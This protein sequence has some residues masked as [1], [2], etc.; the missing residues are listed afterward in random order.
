MFQ[1]RFDGSVDFYRNWAEY[2]DGFG[3]LKG[4]FWLGNDRVSKMT[5]QGDWELRVDMGDWSTPMVKAYAKYNKFRLG[6]STESYTLQLDKNSF[7]G[8]AGEDY[9][10]IF[11]IP[12]IISNAVIFINNSIIKYHFSI[13]FNYE[14]YCTNP[15]V[16]HK[17]IGWLAALT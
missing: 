10:I 6:S 13:K 8:T 14:K 11:A 17:S 4:E 16:T 7:N 12:I 3:D 1:K 9:S 5:Q 2:R 15:R